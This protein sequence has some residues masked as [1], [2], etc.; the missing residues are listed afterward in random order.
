MITATGFHNVKASEVAALF[1]IDP[2]SIAGYV[3]LTVPSIGNADQTPAMFTD[4]PDLTEIINLLA[5]SIAAIAQSMDV[6]P[7]DDEPAPQ[8][9]E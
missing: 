7:P 6:L 1:S 5:V 2:D 3:V 4:S 9:A 8:A